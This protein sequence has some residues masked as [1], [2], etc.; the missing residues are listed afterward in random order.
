MDLVGRS[1]TANLAFS[2][3]ETSGRIVIFGLLGGDIL[4][5]SLP[6]KSLTVQGHYIGTPGE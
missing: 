3:T 2:L 1:G 4:V 6:L 5:S